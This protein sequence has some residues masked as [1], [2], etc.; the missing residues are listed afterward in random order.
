MLMTAMRIQNPRQTSKK[1]SSPPR[2]PTLDIVHVGGRYRVG[3][4]LG[5]GGSGE[6]H[7]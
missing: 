7:I 5:T 2:A 3:K 6:L 4:L 1:Q